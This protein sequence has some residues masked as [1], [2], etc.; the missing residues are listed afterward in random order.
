LTQYAREYFQETPIECDLRVQSELPPLN[1]SAEYRHNVFLAFEESLSNV[2]K[3]ARASRVEVNIQVESGILRIRVS[4]N[5]I[6]FTPEAR[7]GHSAGL[8]RNGLANIRQHLAD[9][10]GSCL[11]QGRP[12]QG[13]SV[14]LKVGLDSLKTEDA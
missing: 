13:A 6:G 5:G 10:G 12:G 4:D 1:V 11:I 3:H 7:N 8:D 9:V 2:L 14:E